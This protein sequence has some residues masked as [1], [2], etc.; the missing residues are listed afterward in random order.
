[1]ICTGN[2]THFILE[3]IQNAEDALAKRSK[4]WSGSRTIS[5]NLLKSEIR[6]EHFGRPFNARDVRGITGTLS[7]VKEDDLTQIGR[8]GVGFK[9]VFGVTDRPKVHSGR[10]DFGIKNLIEPFQ[11]KPLPN[12]NKD[13]TIFI[14]PL[15]EAG[16]NKRP[17]I[18]A[19]LD[20]IDPTVLL[21]LRQ[22]EN[23]A[24]QVSGGQK[25]KLRRFTK[26]ISENVPPEHDHP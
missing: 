7:S 18:V 24:W 6:V 11:V 1:M 15:K 2:P 26:F 3:L 20:D 10:E 12:R 8:F 23:I 25:G 4:G 5:F 9:S 16:K 14:L 17:E 19:W 22:I 21:F 13:A